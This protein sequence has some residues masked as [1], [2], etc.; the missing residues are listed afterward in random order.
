MR[1]IQVSS[2]FTKLCITESNLEKKYTTLFMAVI[3]LLTIP[4]ILLA[5]TEFRRLL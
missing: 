1:N 3:I 4:D 5:P 2:S